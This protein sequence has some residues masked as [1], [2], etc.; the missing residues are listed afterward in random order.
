MINLNS[1]NKK[2]SKSFSKN[3]P[4]LNALVNKLYPDFI[5]QSNPKTIE[6]EIPVFTLHTVEPAKFEEQLNFLSKNNYQTLTADELYDCIKGKYR[7]PER[8]ILLTFDDGWKNVYT[9]AYPLLKKY[10]MKAVCFLIPG[11]IDL[12]NGIVDNKKLSKNDK[13]L[14]T[15]ILCS[16]KE[17]REMHN[18]GVIDFQSHSMYH[19][20]IFISDIIEDFFY[21]SFDTYAYNFNVPIYSINGSD[22]ISRE[23]KPGTPIYRHAS[24]FFGKN[25]YYD[26]QNLRNECIEYVQLNGGDEFFHN[27]NWRKKLINLTQN[28]K[29]KYNESGFYEDKKT[30]ADNLF[31]DLIKS[32]ALIEKQLPGKQ[33]NHFCYPWWE[34]SHIAVE[35]SK[36]AGYVTNFWGFFKERRTNRTGDDPFTIARILTDDFIFRLPGKG[37]K[38]LFNIYQRK[39]SSN[40]N[41]FIKKLFQADKSSFIN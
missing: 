36:K 14:D 31:S 15:G 32:K 10:N 17:I 38:S 20:R 18:S 2:I 24:K 22:N 1:L 21:P 5:Y 23:T 34:G 13:N 40:S 33:V 9:Y 37:R 16:W 28:Y 26:D 19:C 29:S 35:A 7:V 30:Y 6:N 4:E 3:I 27:P 12:E 39:I 25:R 8:S 41:K 11:L